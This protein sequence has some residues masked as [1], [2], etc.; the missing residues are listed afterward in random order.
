MVLGLRPLEGARPIWIDKEDE[1]AFRYIAWCDEPSPEE[2]RYDRRMRSDGWSLSV[3]PA[4]LQAYLEKKGM[5]MICKVSIDRSLRSEYTRSYD[6]NSKKKASF[7][8]IILRAD[9]TVEDSE[10]SIGTWQADRKRA[11]SRSGR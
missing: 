8:I 4:A 10:G 1:S 2:D 11:W 5:D 6:P 7:K 9:G 3:S